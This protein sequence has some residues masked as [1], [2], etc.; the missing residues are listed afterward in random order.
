MKAHQLK[1]VLVGIT[2][3]LLLITSAH[4]LKAVDGAGPTDK[5]ICNPDGNGGV[6]CTG[7]TG[8]LQQLKK[9]SAGTCIFKCTVEKGV[10]VCRGN[11]PTCDKILQ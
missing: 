1:S 3:S 10:E 8:A 9:G 6:I 11:G 5:P 2:T 7:G 4:A